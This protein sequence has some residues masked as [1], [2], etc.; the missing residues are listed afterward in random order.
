MAVTPV[1]G[2][3]IPDLGSVADGPDGFSDLALDIEGTVNGANILTYTPSWTADGNAQPLNPGERSGVY[4]VRN[5]VCQFFAQLTFTS[6]TGGGAGALRVGLPVPARAGML[7]FAPCRLSIPADHPLWMGM[8][9]IRSGENSCIPAF[10]VTSTNS[11]YGYWQSVSAVGQPTSTGV[12][13]TVN[14]GFNIVNGGSI[15]VAGTYLAA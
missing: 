7:Q 3:R 13:R 12:P 11:I 1:Y 9:E 5:K 10:P 2:W 15:T 8:A 14:G 6:S 4:Q